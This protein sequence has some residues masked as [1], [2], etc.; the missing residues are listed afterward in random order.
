MMSDR[1]IQRD[2]EQESVKLVRRFRPIFRA[3][4]SRW[5]RHLQYAVPIVIVVHSRLF[6]IQLRRNRGIANSRL[7]TSLWLRSDA[8][9]RGLRKK[10]QLLRQLK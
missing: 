3:F 5:N 4:S 10:Q 1:T 7:N 2:S 9:V 6:G 8:V